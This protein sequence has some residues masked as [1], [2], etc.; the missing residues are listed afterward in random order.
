MSEPESLSVYLDTCIISG[1]AKEDLP[2]EE[3]RALNSVL[4]LRKSGA[5]QLVT[6]FVVKAELEKI[7]E[8]FRIKH[9]VIYNL[10]SDVPV[11]RFRSITGLGPVG[12]PG[13]GFGRLNRDYL[14]LRQLLRDAEDAKHVYQ[15]IRNGIQVFLTIDLRTILRNRAVVEES[16]LIKLRSPSEF[17]REWG[18][19]TH[20]SRADSG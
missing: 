4:S 17:M 1:L 12:V 15:A 18:S 7:P 3:Y 14:K 8:E 9:E 5:I 20:I 10:L 13:F 2:K 16:F 11:K 19:K 6:S